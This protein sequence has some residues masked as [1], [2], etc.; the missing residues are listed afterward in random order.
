MFIC[1]ITS[2]YEITVPYHPKLCC[3]GLCF[4]ENDLC[5]LIILVCNVIP[6]YPLQPI[7]VSVGLQSMLPVQSDDE[8]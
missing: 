3:V 8:S 7:Q 1:L 2:K 6:A 5:I 4:V